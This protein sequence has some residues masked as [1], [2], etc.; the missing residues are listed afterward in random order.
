MRSD[1]DWHRTA[2]ALVV[3][4]MAYNVVEAGVALWRLA[5]EARGSY[6]DASNG[7]RRSC[8]A[9]SAPP[10]SCSRCT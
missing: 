7:R 1:R 2:L 6:G 10:S 5:L 8:T 4:T 3:T 9:S